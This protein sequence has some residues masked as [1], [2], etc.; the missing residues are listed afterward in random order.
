MDN[1]VE[2]AVKKDVIKWIQALNDEKLLNE[3]YYFKERHRTITP[4][5]KE[6][7]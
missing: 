4:E 7:K 3:L 6:E 5:E 1:K 2:K